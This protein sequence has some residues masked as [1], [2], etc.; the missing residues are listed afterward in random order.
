MTTNIISL[1]DLN[2][3]EPV[4]YTEYKQNFIN[5][6]KELTGRTL[7]E[8]EDEMLLLE[9]FAY[10]LTYRDIA[11]NQRVK[12][13]LPTHAKAENLDTACLNFYG[14]VR[15]EDESDEA[16]LLRSLYSLQQANTA[17]SEWSY[18]YHVTSI[19]KHVIDVFAY[20]SNPGEVT[21]VFFAFFT[22][23]EIK[24]LLEITDS[25]LSDEQIELINTTRVELLNNLQTAIKERLNEDKI[26]PL[27][28]LQ[29]I[30]QATH[31]EYQIRATIKTKLSTNG[32]IA[33][34]EALKNVDNFTKTLKIG[35]EIKTS[36][37][38]SLLHVNGV[39]E[40]IL[41]EPTQNIIIDNESVGICTEIIIT[42]E[43]EADE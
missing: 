24:E 42:Q 5:K 28:E 20:R 30:K 22:D 34:E 35:D 40:V 13:I 36:K 23:E 15:L 2:I 27:N 26:R 37:L 10:E 39:G 4:S 14:T 41:Q 25:E 21:I 8:T 43:V 33:K 7:I 11:I 32:D 1:P 18:Y 38:I 17:G 31:I 29:I 12:S 19:D 3:I 16:F 6:F 9:A